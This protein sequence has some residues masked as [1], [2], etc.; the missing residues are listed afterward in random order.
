MK[1]I[2]KA[3]IRLVPNNYVL[4]TPEIGYD[5]VVVGGKE[6]A[7]DTSFEPEMHSPTSGYVVKCCEHLIFNQN[8]PT[9]TAYDTDVELKG[10]DKVWF[11][12]LAIRLAIQYGQVFNME[13][14]M[15]VAIPYDKIYAGKRGDKVFTVN[16]WYL[17]EPEEKAL[18]KTTLII[19]DTVKGDSEVTG[20]VRFTPTPIRGYHG[21]PE[22]GSDKGYAK[23]GDRVLFRVVDSIPL[24]YAYHANLIG[25]TKMY[26]M[27]EKDILAIL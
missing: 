7:I 8:D 17:I 23:A 18:P 20:T 27:Q 24:Q 13:N 2:R 19:P 5:K 12:F 16:G 9:S 22:L 14:Q 6:I 1:P 26:R 4:V 3:S 10:G 11:H 15:V 25:R 21:H